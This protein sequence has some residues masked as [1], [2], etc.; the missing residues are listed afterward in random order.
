MTLTRRQ[1]QFLIAIADLQGKDPTQ[2][3]RYTAV[4][5]R[6]GVSHITAYNMMRTL[7]KKG[8]VAPHYHLPAEGKRSGRSILLFTLTDVGRA[9]ID[10]DDST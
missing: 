7:M 9:M 1:H 6:L 4:A 5:E 3:V 10:G 2:M 8:C